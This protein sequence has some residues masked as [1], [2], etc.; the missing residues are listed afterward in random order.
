MKGVLVIKN[1]DTRREV[2]RSIAW[3]DLV[4]LQSKVVIPEGTFN[5]LAK[6]RSF[7]V[8]VSQKIIIIVDGRAFGRTGNLQIIIRLV[9]VKAQIDNSALGRVV[10]LDDPIAWLESRMRFLL[11]GCQRQKCCACQY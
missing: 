2:V 11:A 6:V 1:V 7:V 9:R 3:L 5:V 8:T 10:F 4:A